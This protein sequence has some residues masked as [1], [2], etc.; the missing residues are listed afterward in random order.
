LIS[1]DF[2]NLVEKVGN[3]EVSR[4]WKDHRLKIDAEYVGIPNMELAELMA[5]CLKHMKE[6]QEGLELRDKLRP[7]NCALLD[8]ATLLYKKSTS[9]PQAVL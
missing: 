3:P 7:T 5:F 2:A 4:P 8:R 6:I 9:V 1:L